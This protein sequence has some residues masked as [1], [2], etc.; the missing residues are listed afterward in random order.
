MSAA[1]EFLPEGHEFSL[2]PEVVAAWNAASFRH[3]RPM[4]QVVGP[5]EPI[6]HPLSALDKQLEMSIRQE[7]H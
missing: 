1:A 2:P 4:D 7:G 5:E 6:C 3:N